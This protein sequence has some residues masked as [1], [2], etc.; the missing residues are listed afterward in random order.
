MRSWINWLKWGD[1]NTRFFHATTIQ[2]RQ[3]N[4]INLLR[5]ESQVWV[6]DP[7]KLKEMTTNYF[8]QLYTTS[9]PRCYEHILEQCPRVVTSNMNET[10]I[11]QVT[12]EEVKEATFQL[13]VSKAPGPDGLN[14]LFYQSHWDVFK[15]DI[16][17]AVQ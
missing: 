2:R 9:G 13:G 10:L 12:L 16:F 15:V 6:R 17:Q 11:A 8:S 7:G 5:D 3:Q 1:R 14:G 4:R